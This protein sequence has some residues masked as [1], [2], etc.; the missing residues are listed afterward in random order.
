MLVLTLY[1]IYNSQQ[2]KHSTLRK[3][4]KLADYTLI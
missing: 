3:L 4:L 1:G 2:Y